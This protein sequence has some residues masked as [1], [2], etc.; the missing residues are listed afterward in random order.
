MR[1]GPPESSFPRDGRPVAVAAYTSRPRTTEASGAVR[2][3]LCNQ[4]DAD[5]NRLCVARHS[6]LGY[7]RHCLRL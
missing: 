3:M 2:L 1:S 6:L 7:L 4:G 5:C